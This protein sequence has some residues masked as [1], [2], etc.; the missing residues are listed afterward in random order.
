M[1]TDLLAIKKIIKKKTPNFRRQDQYMVKLPENWRRPRGHASKVRTQK[2]GKI[3]RPNV[4]YR[5]PV[6]LRGLDAKG[7]QMVTITNV[8]DLKQLNDK[9]IGVVSAN[10]GLKKREVIAKAAIGKK[11]IFTNFKPETII[12]KVEA[13]KNASQKKKEKKKEE[14]ESKKTEVKEEKKEEQVKPSKPVKAPQPP[15][16]LIKTARPQKPRKGDVE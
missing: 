4:G 13:L 8:E 14:K 2:K 3:R 6:I 15:E 10:L 1:T 9:V 5:T 16:K 12:K 11:Y 7:K